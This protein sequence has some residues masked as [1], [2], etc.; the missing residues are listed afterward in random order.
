ETVA[1]QARWGT[2]PVLAVD[3]LP[4]RLLRGAHRIDERVG[5]R[6]GALA[7]GAEKC[8][9]R[10]P[11]LCRRVFVPLWPMHEGAAEVEDDCAGRA[12]ARSGRR[13]RTPAT[14]TSRSIMSEIVSMSGASA[15]SRS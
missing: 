3:P 9:V 6:P 2:A 8:V 12:H 14:R 5:R 7:I 10:E 11:P 4:V 1:H 15:R 13:T